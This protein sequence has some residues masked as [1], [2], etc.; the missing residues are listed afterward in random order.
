MDKQRICCSV[1]SYFKLRTIKVC[2]KCGVMEKRFVSIWFP[3][4]STDWFSLSQFTL[5]KRSG[6]GGP[7]V[8]R[9]PSHGR[10]IIS[11]TNAQAEKRGINNGMALADARA[12]FPELE[13][14]DD[15]PD[16]IDKLLKRLAEWC[17]RFTPFVAVDP[18]DGLLLDATGCCHLW[19]G[20]VSYINEVVKKLNARGYDVRAAMAD[21][22]GVACGIA[23]FGQ[24]KVIQPGQHSE[25][26][27]R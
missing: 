18:P 24:E 4:L 25:A 19:G 6:E 11:A 16:L 15:K 2:T 26:L 27:I 23:R 1:S 9:T 8:L 7:F 22:V 3:H 14:Q 20:D 17:I 21:T 5:P 10:M 12:I 13:V